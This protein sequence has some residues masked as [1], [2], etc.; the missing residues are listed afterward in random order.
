MFLLAYG[1]DCKISSRTWGF[2]LGQVSWQGIP[3]AVKAMLRAGAGVNAAKPG[4]KPLQ[5]ARLGEHDEVCKL[6]K[7]NERSLA[8]SRRTESGAQKMRELT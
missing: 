8:L 2:P 6:L 4:W 3:R 7:E 5:L 1:A